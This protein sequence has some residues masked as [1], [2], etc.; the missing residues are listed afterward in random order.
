M[1][2]GTISSYLGLLRAAYLLDEV[3]GWVPPA[4][5]AKRV[6]TKPKRYLADP[7]LAVAQ[8]ALLPGA[9]LAD[10]QTFGLVFENLCMRDLQVYAE[11]QE[12]C[13]DVPVRYYRDS[14][15][16]EV[17]AIVEL[18]DGRWGAFEIKTSEAKVEEGAA[19]L[20]RLRRKLTQ[21][22]SARVRPPEFMAVITGVSEYAHRV[23]D[24]IYAIPICAL[25]A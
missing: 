9:L 5:S 3:P 25:T 7:S 23:E 24:G 10:W 1:S 21:N 12:L 22:P 13:S 15:G 2:E 8:L 11:A 6:N 14:A 20:R 4:R 18:A 19:S 17:D 16:L